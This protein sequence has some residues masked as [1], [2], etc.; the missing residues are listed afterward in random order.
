VLKRRHDYSTDM[1]NFQERSVATGMFVSA[2]L[3]V[4]MLIESGISAKVVIVNDNNDID[5]EVKSY[6]ATHVFIEGYWVVPEKFDV[7]KPLYPNVE[8]IVRCHS[9]TPFLAVEGIAFDWT[10]E[11]LRRG[12][13][14]AA[15]SPR[16]HD[17][18]TV[19]AGGLSLSSEQVRRQLVLLT[20][21]YVMREVVSSP[22]IFSDDVLDIGCF[23]AVRLLKNH[24]IQAI[25]AY[26][27]AR[28]VGK[29]LRFHINS[30]R[31]EA[32]GDNPLKNLRA[33]FKGLRHAELVEH[34]WQGHSDF[35]R[36]LRDMNILLQVSFSETFNIVTADAVVMGVP[37]LTSDEVPFIR[38]KTADPTSSYDIAQ[39]IAFVLNN[40]EHVVRENQRG[41][42]EY[43]D[44]TRS[45]W[46]SWFAKD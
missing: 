15:N 22:K 29:K 11:Y 12:A 9:E 45:R 8:W 46:L 4:E 42:M 37:V 25:A 33:F 41:L 30:G 19:F 21:F 16:M 38:S 44:A 17:E 35:M 34:P 31:I 43:S 20:N 40:R 28:S 39:K 6:G 32:A 10:R 5:R 36:L 1:A 2:S 13:C 27:Y 7:L 23:G 24:L 3:V 14:V 18:F 26:E